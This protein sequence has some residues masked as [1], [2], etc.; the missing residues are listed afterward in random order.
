MRT[1]RDV[2]AWARE[3][4]PWIRQGKHFCDDPHRI[5]IAMKGG[6]HGMAVR[7]FLGPTTIEEKEFGEGEKVDGVEV[8]LAIQVLSNERGEQ[9]LVEALYIR[10][11]NHLIDKFVAVTDRVLQEF[12]AAILEGPAIEMGGRV[13]EEEQSQF[14]AIFDPQPVVRKLM[15]FYQH[16]GGWESRPER[17]RMVDPRTIGRE[18]DQ[19]EKQAELDENTEIEREILEEQEVLDRIVLHDEEPENTVVTEVDF[20][21]LPAAEGE[22]LDP[23]EE[24]N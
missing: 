19:Q 11:W 16:F 18:L 3:V 15:V 21:T 2:A 10:R 17:W 9:L 12:G 13:I 1:M 5:E 8:T 22:D 14:G 23:E 20:N 24:A 6:A 4:R 7:A